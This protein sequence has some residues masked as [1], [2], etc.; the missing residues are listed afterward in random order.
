MITILAIV[1]LASLALF[2]ELISRAP[3]MDDDK[4]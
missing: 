3:E 1:F 4:L 2:L